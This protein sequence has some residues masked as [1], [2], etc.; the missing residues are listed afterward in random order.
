MATALRVTIP[1]SARSYPEPAIALDERAVTNKRMR[2]KAHTDLMGFTAIMADVSAEAVVAVAKAELMREL[3]QDKVDREAREH[4]ERVERLKRLTRIAGYRIGGD[5][6]GGTGTIL[7]TCHEL[8]SL[9]LVELHLIRASQGGSA[10]RWHG[11]TRRFDTTEH[12]LRST[13][14]SRPLAAR[15]TRLL[16][17]RSGSASSAAAKVFPIPA[18]SFQESDSVPG[19][20]LAKQR[21]AMTRRHWVIRGYDGSEQ[22]FERA[23]PEGLL[24][25]AEMKIVLQRLACRHLSDEEVVSA[26]LRKNAAGYRADL[27]VRQSHGGRFTLM[28][29]GTGCHYAATVEELE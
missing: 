12:N 25:E 17:A 5:Q 4:R 11:R 20:I 1:R 29:A 9:Q 3:P 19:V 28:T 26:S 23:L 2:G 18:F 21:L 6:S 13:S 27:E 14:V 16:R 7:Q 10:A 8:T 24:S 22:T 15:L